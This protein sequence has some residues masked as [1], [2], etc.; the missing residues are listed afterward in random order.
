MT[1]ATFQVRKIFPAVFAVVATVAVLAIPQA[2]MA[3]ATRTSQSVTISDLDLS[4]LGDQQKLESRIRRAARGACGLEDVQT[5]TRLRSP[6]ATECYRKAL[7]SVRTRV[8][9]A[10]AKASRG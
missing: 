10:I 4:S 5:G 6:G 8:A 3:E 9:E 7:R 2:A 1:N